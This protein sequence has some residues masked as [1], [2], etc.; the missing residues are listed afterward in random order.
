M[1]QQPALQP[2]EDAALKVFLGELRWLDCDAQG[3][4]VWAR[5]PRRPS[6]VWVQARGW[7][8]TLALQRVAWLQGHVV[9]RDGDDVVDLD[10]GSAVITRSL[11]VGDLLTAQPAAG[12]CLQVGR[13]V[14]CICAVEAL[15]EGLWGVDLR[16]ES[17]REVGGPG[18]ALSEPAWWLEVAE[19]HRRLEAAASAAAG[20]G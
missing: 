18:G 7:P 19:A 8:G 17:A 14:S 6:R 20:P 13:Y 1:S 9:C 2:F 11:D 3:R 12:G 4:T 5:L 15:P 16:V 10:D